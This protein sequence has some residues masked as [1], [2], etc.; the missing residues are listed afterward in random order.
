MKNKMKNFNIM[1]NK[2]NLRLDI[3]NMHKM[4]K[5]CS[6]CGYNKCGAALDF[7]HVDENEKYDTVSQLVNRLR[8][9]E[10]IL[11]EAKKCIILCANCHREWHNK[12]R[13]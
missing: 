11:E 10:V 13:K 2:R 1:N 9:M 12:E 5:G 4:A 7:H 8:S 3:L 6:I